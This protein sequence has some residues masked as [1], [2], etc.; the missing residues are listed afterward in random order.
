MI[1]KDVTV[2]L[3]SE[4]KPFKHFFRATGYANADYTYTPPVKRMYDC[5]A[6]YQGYPLYMRLHNILSLHGKGDYYITREGLD[7]GNPVINGSGQVDIVV[8]LDEDGKPVFN[9]EPVD[10]VYDIIIGHGMHPIM[11]AVYMPGCI[12]RSDT[13]YYLPKTFA[14][15]EAVTEAFVKHWINRYGIDE[16]RE[17][18]FEICNEPEQYPLWNEDPSSFFAL[19]DYFEHAIHRIDTRLKVGG[20][21]VKQWEDGQRLYKAF[22]RH[23]HDGSNY[24]TGEYGTRL[25]F[26]SVHSKGGHPD[27]VGPSMDYLFNPLREFAAVLGEFPDFAGIEFFND[28]SDIVWEGNMGISHKS[29]LNFRNTHYAPGFIGKMIHQYCLILQDE[30]NL[31]LSIVD[32]DNCHL[33]WEK[34]FFSGNRSQFTPLGPAPCTDFI[35]KPMFNIFPLLGKLGDERYTGKNND[36]EFG[37]KYGVLATRKE[38]ACYSFLLWNFED[39]LSDDVNDRTIRL[40]LENLD[41]S[42]CYDVLHYRIDGSTSNAYAAWSRMGKPYPLTLEQTALIREKEELELYDAPSCFSGRD[43]YNAEVHLPLH[44]VSLLLLVRRSEPAAAGSERAIANAPVLAAEKGVLGNTQVFIRWNF[45]ERPDLAGY[46][47]YRGLG[48]DDPGVCINKDKPLQCSYCVDMDVS[49]GQSLSYSVSVVYAD[50][51]ES[52]RSPEGVISL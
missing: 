1:F 14:L 49:G 26:I 13:E 51:T 41:A 4:T 3:R 23:C 20:P 32:S 11:E 34:S 16:V 28:E 2:D 8:S 44:A 38:E 19:Y 42:A 9:W 30:L 6:S 15:W 17:W 52:G 24:R 29:W 46:Y 27:L 7:Y 21:A 22:L 45:S 33:P 12:A 40:R 25:D 31:N 5:L 48:T 36:P 50:G 35:K 18:Y 37:T 39:G 47:I 43:S 10:A